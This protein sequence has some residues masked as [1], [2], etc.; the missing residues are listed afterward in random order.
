MDD[1]YTYLSARAAIIVES[2]TPENK[3]ATL[4]VVVM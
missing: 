3:M 2:I 1:K 4:D